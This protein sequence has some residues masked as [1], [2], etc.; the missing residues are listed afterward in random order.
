ML[1]AYIGRFEP[2]GKGISLVKL[3][4]L[5][6]RTRLSSSSIHQSG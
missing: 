1:G 4:D 5:L 6:T 2:G 3:S